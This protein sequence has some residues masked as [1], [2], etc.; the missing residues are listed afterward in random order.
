MVV[1]ACFL[2]Y[3]HIAYLSTFLSTGR[4]TKMLTLVLLVDELKVTRFIF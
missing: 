2:H 4:G 1:F 3:T